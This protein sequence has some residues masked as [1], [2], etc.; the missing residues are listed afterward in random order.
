MRRTGIV[1]A[2]AVS[3]IVVLAVTSSGCSRSNDATEAGEG[4]GPLEAYLAQSN[5]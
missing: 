2:A 3:A 5:T 1:R 4:G